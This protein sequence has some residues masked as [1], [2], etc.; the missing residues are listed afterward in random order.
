MF[1]VKLLNFGS[2]GEN[3]ETNNNMNM[4]PYYVAPE[5]IDNKFDVTSD[6]WSIGVIIYQ[7]FYY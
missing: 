2:Y 7:M 5:I 1:N 6:V 4:L 3:I